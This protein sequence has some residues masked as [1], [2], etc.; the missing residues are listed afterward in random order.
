MQTKL[1]IKKIVID[2]TFNGVDLLKIDVEGFEANVLTGMQKTIR[3]YKPTA[4]VEILEPSGVPKILELFGEG[5]KFWHID[6][7]TGN[8]SDD[9]TGT[10]KIFIH[11]DHM[12]L[13]NGYYN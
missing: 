6:E 3:K 2:S 5:Y 7:L 13:L 11:E 1:P 4:I 8:L 9:P 12:S 10:N